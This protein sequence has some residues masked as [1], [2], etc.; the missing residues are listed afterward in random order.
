[1]QRSKCKE[2]KEKS[3]RAKCKVQNA[4]LSANDQ[5]SQEVTGYKDKCQE[6]IRQWLFSFEKKRERVALRFRK[7]F[8]CCIENVSP[9]GS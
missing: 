3:Q 4:K 8:Q 2:Q 7:A 6:M 9:K 1:M 5:S